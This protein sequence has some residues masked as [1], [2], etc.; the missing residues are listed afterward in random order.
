MSLWTYFKKFFSKSPRELESK[1]LE[2]IMSTLERIDADDD[3]AKKKILTLIEHNNQLKND[4]TVLSS[5][6]EIPYKSSYQPKPEEVRNFRMGVEKTKIAIK[7]RIIDLLEQKDESDSIDIHK[8]MVLSE[9]VRLTIN[10]LSKTLEIS[11]SLAKYGIDLPTW[12]VFFGPPWVGKTESARRISTHHNLNFKYV[13]M[14]DIMHGIVGSSEKTMTEVFQD[15]RNQT[16]NTWK[17]TII[18]IDEADKLLWDRKTQQHSLVQHF[19]SLVDGFYKNKW[20]ITILSTNEI[21]LIDKAVLSRM[22]E[23]VEFNLP[24]TKEIEQLLRIHLLKWVQD[25]AIKKIFTHFLATHQQQ[26]D[27]LYTQLC[28]SGASGRDIK[29]ISHTSKR[30]FVL[31]HITNDQEQFTWDDLVTA[32]E[33][34]MWNT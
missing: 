22:A 15:A 27:G 11:E 5:L 33:N 21:Q 13:S 2:E 9:K 3:N 23:K 34:V 10:A 4:Y 7:L 19:L 12:L 18:F 17:P 14:S 24:N 30:T 8:E 25:E 16:L 29:N 1:G 31:R 28:A 6:N 32:V 26:L 20:T